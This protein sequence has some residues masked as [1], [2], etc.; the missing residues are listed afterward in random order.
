MNLEAQL[1]E[2]QNDSNVP[3]HPSENNC[4]DNKIK[5]STLE[6]KTNSLE[7]QLSILT[8]MFETFQTSKKTSA[9][10][11]TNLYLCEVCNWECTD[12]TTL[13]HH[14]ESAHIKILKCYLCEY[15]T[16]DENNLQMHIRSHKQASSCKDCSFIAANEELLRNHKEIHHHQQK[17]AENLNK[18]Y[19]CD[20]CR[21]YYND[22]E[23]LKEHKEAAHR[24]HQKCDFCEYTTADENNLRRHVSNH[25]LTLTC[26]ECKFSAAN[27]D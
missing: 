24:Q 7:H 3:T 16:V 18:H 4:E 26:K 1:K 25:R 2:A 21:N 15:T 17:S 11:M 27:V 5:I 10:N 12:K 20:V 14:K 13:K 6:T 8:S 19:S 22:R 23:S 9:E